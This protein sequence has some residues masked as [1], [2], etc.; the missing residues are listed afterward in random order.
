MHNFVVR[1]VSSGGDYLSCKWLWML[2]GRG[3]VK[4]CQEVYVVVLSQG[5]RIWL[6]LLI[7][8][9]FIQTVDGSSS[10]PQCGEPR[11]FSLQCTLTAHTAS[12]HPHEPSSVLTAGTHVSRY[13]HWGDSLGAEGTQCQSLVE[14]SVWSLRYHLG[15][16][17]LSSIFF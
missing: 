17:V 6:K 15:S 14:F 11:A 1:S 13:R 12:E 8:S 7:P 10:Q 4:W 5:S 16:Q 2:W 9:K 3:Q